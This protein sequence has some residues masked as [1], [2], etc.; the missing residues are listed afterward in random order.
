MEKFK[1][2]LL[3]KK[4]VFVFKCLVYVVLSAVFLFLTFYRLGEKSVFSWDEARHGISAYEML[5]NDNYI[6]N[7]YNY[8][9]DLW[10][11]KP[12]LSF[13]LEAISF[14][15]LGYSVFAFRFPSAVCFSVL[16]FS[17]CG[18]LHRNYG[19]LSSVIFMLMFS[20][21]GD[22]FFEHFGRSG[23]ADAYFNL[24]F[25]YTFLFLF[26]LNKTGKFLYLYLSGLM[27]SLGFL[28]KSFHAVILIAVIVAYVVLSRQIFRLR[29]YQ[30]AVF[31]LCAVLPIGIWMAFR[32]SYDGMTFL[33]SMFGV[34]VMERT[35]VLQQVGIWVFL[36]KILR[37]RIVQIILAVNGITAVVLFFGKKIKRSDFFNGTFILYFCTLIIPTAFYV[38]AQAI[39][40]WYYFPSFLAL[41][42]TGAV[43]FGKAADTVLSS[44][45]TV[46]ITSG[47]LFSLMVTAFLTRFIILNIHMTQ[48]FTFNAQQSALKTLVDRNGSYGGLKTYIV[49]DNP[50]FGGY[51][52]T[53][54]Q[55][56]IL[57]AELYCD[58]KCRDGGVNA[59]LQEKNAVLFISENNYQKFQD[60]FVACK[61][62]AQNTDYKVLYR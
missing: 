40:F 23:D 30:Y 45:K 7:T 41:L 18:F 3:H 8:N 55:C 47:I 29:L 10:N 15:L 28:S 51:A 32:Y 50:Y 31:F 56:D 25:V 26:Y 60:K 44:K 42:I 57:V 52:D 48:T 14:K 54:E 39:N 46:W 11:L 2:F 9:K 37:Y 6:I 19:F 27:F 4:T 13:W 1:N 20:A 24:F 36:E 34:D 12:P 43:L 53:W 61:V 21:F 62:I 38:I 17:L 35:Q 5:Q 59:F 49:T 22:L 58:A 16:F 33:G